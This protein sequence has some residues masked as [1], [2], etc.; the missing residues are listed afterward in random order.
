MSG[1]HR[2]PERAT[3]AL[4][5]SDSLTPR[6]LQATD[7]EVFEGLLLGRVLE[8]NDP[9]LCAWELPALTPR[10]RVPFDY[11]ILLCS[12]GIVRILRRDRGA[13][14][15]YDP[16]TGAL[17]QRSTPLEWDAVGDLFSDDGETMFHGVADGI[18]VR[19]LADGALL[20]SAPI[21]AEWST[22]TALSRETVIVQGDEDAVF[23]LDRATLKTRWTLSDMEVGAL[24]PSG[25]RL[26]LSV[27]PYEAPSAPML[28][29]VDAAT[30]ETRWSQ[31]TQCA[32][33]SCSND[34]LLSADDVGWVIAHDTATG[35][36]RWQQWLGAPVKAAVPH[37]DGFI[38]LTHN[39]LVAL[40]A[41]GVEYARWSAQSQREFSLVVWNSLLLCG[42]IS[43]LDALPTEALSP[44]KVSAPQLRHSPRTP[45]VWPDGI[46]FRAPRRAN[47][48]A[49][50]EVLRSIE[51]RDEA[52]EALATRGM[53]PA[54][55]V[56]NDARRFHS[57]ADRWELCPVGRGAMLAFASDIEG[58]TR[59]EALMR[60]ALERLS[61]WG[62][63]NDGS[64]RWELC[65]ANTHVL[66]PPPGF[67]GDAPLRALYAALGAEAVNAHRVELG[68][69]REITFVWNE[70]TLH[71]VILGDMLWRTA[72]L[73]DVTVCVPKTHP[74]HE[75]RFAELPNPFEP[76]VAIVATGYVFNAACTLLAFRFDEDLE[77]CPEGY[78][79]DDIPF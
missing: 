41:D 79:D 71:D 44:R 45:W 73:N 7:L 20:R 5:N 76:L 59:C 29:A 46:A 39:A 65:G 72:V 32:P 6:A 77:R 51:D 49:L 19:A 57:S 15:L 23:G 62:A 3:L 74:L 50:R 31:Q 4:V 67:T 75:R 18:N 52:W 47:L 34:V 26:Y 28:L 38:A 33:R 42:N 56:H 78:N 12:G 53:I 43:G 66:T 1:G 64:L 16:K 13:Y 60:E 10:W 70:S 14:E 35:E 55:W 17:L 48:D 11:G 30:G 22:V 37:G 40:D 27:R 25:E 68:E 58:V 2:G 21:G 61:P 36:A 9:W 8:G 69:A 54:S 63:L 24:I